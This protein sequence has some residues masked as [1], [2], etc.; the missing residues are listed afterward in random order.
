MPPAEQQIYADTQ[1][2]LIQ[3]QD[4]RRS[5]S[6]AFYLARLSSKEN[7]PVGYHNMVQT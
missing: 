4:T 1:M 5:E 6:R 2:I 3:Q 7:E